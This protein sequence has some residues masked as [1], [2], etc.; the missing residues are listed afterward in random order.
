M[1]T[2]SQNGTQI[3]AQTYQKSM[4]KLVLGM[5]WKIASSIGR[6]YKIKVSQGAW[7]NQEIN[8]EKT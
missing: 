2:G 7:P 3:D 8:K 6:M 1:P 4:P 5:I